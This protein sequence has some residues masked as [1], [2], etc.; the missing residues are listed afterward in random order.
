MGEDQDISALQQENE[1][2]REQVATLT[3]ERERWQP[4]P[5][6]ATPLEQASPPQGRFLTGPV[7][8]FTWTAREGW[9][10]ESVSPTIAQFGYTAEDFLT[11]RMS[12][13]ELVHPDD[14][15]RVST[16]VQQYST[17]GYTAFEQEYRLRNAAGETHWIYDYT[18]IMRDEQG[19]IT[20]YIGYIIDTTERKRQEEELRMFKALAENA[21]DGV[22]IGALDGTL[23]YANQTLQQ[24][25]GIGPDAYGKSVLDFYPPDARRYVEATVLPTIMQQ[26]AW[27]GVLELSRPDGSRWLAQHSTFV[28]RDE[29]GQMSKIANLL[30]D[31]TEQNRQEAERVALQEQIIATQQDALR[32]LST[33]LIPISDTVVIM[34]LIGT[35]DNRRSKQVLETL[36]EGVAQYQAELVIIDITGVQVVDTQV[37]QA[38]IQA[39]Q[40]VRLLGAQVMLTGIQ[41]AIAQ[42]LIHLGVDLQGI[43]THASLQAGIAAALR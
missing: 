4:V 13:A 20:H 5:R 8:L 31:V 10:V 34:P 1:R 29:Q 24:M 36:L 9:P 25:V 38:F 3:R 16:E 12:Y 28:L 41:P 14:L 32:E 27:Q 22:G 17:A 33:P 39:A 18:T 6:E 11:G 26:G 40:A 43:I 15:E 23:L 2:L 7:V 21:L 30:R 37:A 35:I 19:T 42:T